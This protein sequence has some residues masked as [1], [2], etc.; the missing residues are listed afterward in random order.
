[1]AA[2]AAVLRVLLTVR[3][4]GTG[5]LIPT[6]HPTYRHAAAPFLTLAV[7]ARPMCRMTMICQSRRPIVRRREPEMAS[8][9]STTFFKFRGLPF[10]LWPFQV[11]F[12]VSSSVLFTRPQRAEPCLQVSCMSTSCCI[13]FPNVCFDGVPLPLG[14]I[15]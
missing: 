9:C 10:Q 15:C 7:A 5:Q 1:M 3:R 12:C 8:S 13:T 14:W 11:P 6:Q 4:L 2:S